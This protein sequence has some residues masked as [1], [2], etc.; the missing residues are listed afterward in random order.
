M[1]VS[2]SVRNTAGLLSSELSNGLEY[3]GGDA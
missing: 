2:M 1:R 3:S